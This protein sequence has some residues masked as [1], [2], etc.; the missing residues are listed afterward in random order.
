MHIRDIQ[1]GHS[2]VDLADF[3]TALLALLLVQLLS[4][5]GWILTRRPLHMWNWNVLVYVVIMFFIGWI[6]GKNPAFTVIPGVTHTSLC[7]LRLVTGILM[8]IFSGEWLLRDSSIIA[9]I[10][11]LSSSHQIKVAL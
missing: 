9:S 5:D 6:E 4:D 2:L 10:P 3:L 8:L 1:L 7:T 11:R